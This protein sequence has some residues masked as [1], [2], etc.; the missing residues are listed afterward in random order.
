MTLINKHP[1]LVRRLRVSWSERAWTP[2]IIVRPAART[3]RSCVGRGHA[4][5]PAV[6]VRQL[7]TYRL[8]PFKINFMKNSSR[9]SFPPPRGFT[10]IELLVVISIIGILAGLLLPA[11]AA[12]RKKAQIAKANTEMAGIVAA[13]NQYEQAYS[14]FP[15]TSSPGAADSVTPA[16]PDFTFG[17]VLP[18]GTVLTDRNGAA[19]PAIQNVGNKGY[20]NCNAEVMG[21]LLDLTQYGD[22]TD[23]VNKNHSKNP[24]KTVFLNVKP[25]SDKKS[26]GI[27]LDGVYRDP[28]G[29]PYIITV[30]LNYDNKTRDAFYRNNSVSQQSGS[31]GFNGLYGVTGNNDFEV[32][33]TVAVWS[34][35]P[36]G[37][38]DVGIK[39]NAGVNKDNVLTWK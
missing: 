30:D 17:T 5:F 32:N 14:R 13:I 1:K 12:A 15:S 8:Q 26:P 16:C 37:R 25:V 22:G 31:T 39:A 38:A 23:T 6:Q 18:S 11:L 2:R 20:Q 21:I 10:L 29:N 36:D 3:A 19:L 28:W 9:R 34:L 27:G 7:R 4:N 33:S 35:G 24:Q